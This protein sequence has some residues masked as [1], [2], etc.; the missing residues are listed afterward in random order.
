MQ[1]VLKNICEYA[2]VKGPQNICVPSSEY[3]YSKGCRID[4]AVCNWLSN[5][6]ILRGKFYHFMWKKNF[7]AYKLLIY[8]LR[9]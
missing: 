6:V 3:L 9:F 7:L 8:I 5:S 4:E 2:Y 1:K